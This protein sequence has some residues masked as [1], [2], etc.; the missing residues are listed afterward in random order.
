M[1]KGIK[2]LSIILIYVATASTCIAQ[3]IPFFH[4]KDTALLL[5]AKHAPELLTDKNMENLILDR[6]PA[7]ILGLTPQDQKEL[8]S[9][10]FAMERKKIEIREKLIK[11]AQRIGDTFRLIDSSGLGKYDFK[12]KRFPV[13][14]DYSELKGTYIPLHKQV[15]LLWIPSFRIDGIEMGA[16]KAEQLVKRVPKGQRVFAVVT[17]KVK[18]FDALGKGNRYG[19]PTINVEVENFTIYEKQKSKKKGTPGFFQFIN[20]IVSYDKNEL[21]NKFKSKDSY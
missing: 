20:P 9:N 7:S 2:I 21:I 15:S 18:D 19:S 12:K 3:E 5:V 13:R 11:D 1:K 8:R 4:F 14:F 10:E 17:V 16:D 6:K